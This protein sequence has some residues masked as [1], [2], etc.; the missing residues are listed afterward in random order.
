MNDMDFVALIIFFISTIVYHSTYYFIMRLFPGLAVK[1]NVNLFRRSWISYLLDK[2]D[3]LL[4]VNQG[5]DLITINTFLASAI[6]I[7]MGALLNLLINADRIQNLSIIGEGFEFKVLIL[8]IV[9]GFSF[10]FFLSSLRNYRL[11]VML[12]PADPDLVEKETGITALDYFTNMVNRASNNYTIGSRAIFYALPVIL[13]IGSVWLFI[14]STVIMTLYFSLWK[15]YKII[16]KG[17]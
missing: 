11:F 7:L 4:A 17:R 8:I 15:D 12:I 2:K 1:T 3:Y 6:L 14:S 13:W 10:F 16:R 9:L 5:R